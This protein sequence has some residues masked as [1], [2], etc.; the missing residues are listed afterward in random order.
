MVLLLRC[1]NIVVGHDYYDCLC[2]FVFVHG[3]VVKCVGF[4]GVYIDMLCV[5]VV[6]SVVYVFLF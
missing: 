6:D 2:L 3:V 1:V 5:V 4:V